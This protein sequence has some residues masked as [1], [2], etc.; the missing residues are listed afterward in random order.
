MKQNFNHGGRPP[1]LN[2]AV[3]RYVVRFDATENVKFLTQ[4]ERSGATNKAAFIKNVMLGK[5]FK[6][7]S[8]DG[9]TREFIDKLS[10]INV[11]YRT[12]AIEYDTIVRT[13]RENFSERKA[14]T[15]LYKLEQLTIDFIKTNKEIINLARV[16]DENWRVKNP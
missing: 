3:F 4:Y 9:N 6:I 1:K 12:V 5:T 15:A 8:V 2:P 11:H 16:F 7:I 10:S 14:M 13:L